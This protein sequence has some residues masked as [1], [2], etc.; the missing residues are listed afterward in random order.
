MS[1]DN[2]MEKDDNQEINVE[3]PSNRMPEN[4]TFFER[5]V[6]ILLIVLAVVMASLILFALGVL[7]GLVPF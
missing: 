6:P 3:K 4:S 5:V 1:A 7:I 2:P